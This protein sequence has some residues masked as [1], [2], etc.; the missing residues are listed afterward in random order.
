MQVSVN[1]VPL[2]AEFFHGGEVASSGFVAGLVAG[3]VY[4]VVVSEQYVGNDVACFSPLRVLA[5]DAL[6]GG[7]FHARAIRALL[8][9]GAEDVGYRHDARTQRDL[10][11]A[12]AERVTATVE[13]LVVEGGPRKRIVG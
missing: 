2:R 1:P 4:V 9:D 7:A 11:F 10:A 5:H 3:G 6:H 8:G 13:L 12:K